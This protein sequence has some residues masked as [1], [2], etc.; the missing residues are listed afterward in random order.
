MRT[1][2]SGHCLMLLVLDTGRNMSLMEPIF[3]LNN[4]DDLVED[5]MRYCN[6]IA[7]A[8]DVPQ[9]DEIV[10]GNYAL[11][12]AKARRDTL[13]NGP[14][15]RGQTQPSRRTEHTGKVARL[16]GL[17]SLAQR[18]SLECSQTIFRPAIPFVGPR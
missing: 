2:T 12:R 16:P 8:A 4:V 17:V 1:M 6:S 18:F 9:P 7:A 11:G 15:W 5:I 10:M 3:T 14:S 13:C